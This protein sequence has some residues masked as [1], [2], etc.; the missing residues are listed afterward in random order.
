MKRRKTLSD[1]RLF[2]VLLS[3][4]AALVSSKFDIIDRSEKIQ[5]LTFFVTV[6]VH[7][8]RILSVK[9]KMKELSFLGIYDI[10]TA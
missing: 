6:N 2:I 3:V 10:F 7:G 4:T 5:L 9:A 1:F 8:R